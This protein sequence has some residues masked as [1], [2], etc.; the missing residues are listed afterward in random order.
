M[1]GEHYDPP[2]EH[3]WAGSEDIDH[4]RETGQEPPTGRCACE[5]ANPVAVSE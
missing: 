1:M 3:G 4:A 2:Q 5:C